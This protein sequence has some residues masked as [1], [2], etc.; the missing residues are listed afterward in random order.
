MSLLAKCYE[1]SSRY[2]HEVRRVSFSNSIDTTVNAVCSD[3]DK[4]DGSLLRDKTGG[5]CLF[6][7]HNGGNTGGSLWNFLGAY[8]KLLKATVVSICPHGTSLLP[9]DGFFCCCLNIISKDFLSSWFR[10]S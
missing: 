10:A 4:S 6:L 3:R 9:L 7:V 5:E 1:L 2:V 8:G